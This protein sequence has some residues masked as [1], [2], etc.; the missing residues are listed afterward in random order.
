MLV[1]AI[2]VVVSGELLVMV[3]SNVCCHNSKLDIGIADLMLDSPATGGIA[4][5]PLA[6]LLRHQNSHYM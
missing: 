2:H 3:V 5:A 6:R 4:V 1:S